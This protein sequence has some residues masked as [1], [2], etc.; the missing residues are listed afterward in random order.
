MGSLASC[1][2]LGNYIVFRV[3][4]SLEPSAARVV[5]DAVRNNPLQL[6][7]IR[8]WQVLCPQQRIIRIRP[9]RTI[10]NV[11]EHEDSIIISFNK[12]TLQVRFEY[13]L[14]GFRTWRYKKTLLANAERWLTKLYTSSQP[15]P[16]PPSPLPTRIWTPS[17][18]THDN[19]LEDLNISYYS[20]RQKGYL[21]TI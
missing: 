19:L 15:Q 6:E 17:L 2:C 7:N 20:R 10:L 12:K 16:P 9:L 21:N 4:L 5:Y 1:L 8:F 11:N 3:A 13:Q 14:G 18:N